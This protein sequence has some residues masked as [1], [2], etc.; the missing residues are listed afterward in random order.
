MFVFS[1]LYETK[2]SVQCPY[3]SRKELLEILN[4]QI[5]MFKINGFNNTLQ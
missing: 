1:I 3:K 5:K 4:Y 2:T